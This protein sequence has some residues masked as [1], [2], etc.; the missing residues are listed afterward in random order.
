VTVSTANDYGIFK[1]N[2]EL[3]NYL[4]QKSAKGPCKHLLL[5][6]TFA[7]GVLAGAKTVDDRRTT[8]TAGTYVK[9][10]VE[11]ASYKENAIAAMIEIGDEDLPGLLKMKLE[12]SAVSHLYARLVLGHENDE[13][14]DKVLD[15]LI[16]ADISVRASACRHV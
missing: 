10:F 7:K 15:E 3:L 13:N 9:P 16:R 4:L 8:I 5:Y 14:C 11:N 6:L 12:Q 2:D 1:A